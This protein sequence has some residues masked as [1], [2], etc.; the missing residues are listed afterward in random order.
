MSTIEYVASGC[1]FWRLNHGCL[2]RQPDILDILNEH[3]KLL[4][5]KNHTFSLLYNAYTEKKFGEKFRRC[6]KNI[7]KIHAD[8]GGLQAIT[9]GVK[10][11]DKFKQEVYENQG[12]WADI[13]MSFDE[14]PVFSNDGSGTSD[15]LGHA[16]R[17]FD[18]EL[19][20]DY[21]TKS[22]NNL[23]KQIETFLD[24]GSECKPFFIAQGRDYETYM[25]WAEIAS[26]ILGDLKQ[27]VGGIAMG[28]LALGIG[29]LEEIE[30]AFLYRD[31]PFEIP[32]KAVHI[33]ACGSFKKIAPTLL[34]L[35]SGFYPENTHF[36]YDSTTHT[37]KP[38]YGNYTHSNGKTFILS[39]KMNEKYE[40]AVEDINKTLGTNIDVKEFFEGVNL[41][42]EEYKN[43]Y[44]NYG[45]IQY[46]SMWITA[47]IL[48][49][50]NI[51]DEY[52]ET[53]D[54]SIFI[55]KDSEIQI[56]EKLKEIK[57][58]DDFYHWKKHYGRY[59]QSIA[60]A[61]QKPAS[62]QDLI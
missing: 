21:A 24:A 17:Y 32:H 4:N 10:T 43:K 53:Q 1:A 58:K 55:K 28:G 23:K 37:S 7:D 51:V 60:V 25:R 15:K 3:H 59:L 30:R 20:E 39:R 57:N 42:T 2:D 11:D 16:T 34:F 5:K 13:G 33:L 41:G 44:G 54:L 61:D 27:H 26:D 19:F 31:L 29:P 8:S 36:S 12:K 6:Y 9:T 49:F 48:Q 38:N 62:F 56:Y 40:V 18:K 46:I 50:K 22:A 14:V 52:V 47:Q 45:T 35:E